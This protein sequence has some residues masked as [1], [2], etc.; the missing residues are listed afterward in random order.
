[1]RASPGMR[2]V[3][4]TTGLVL[5]FTQEASLQR[6][7][8]R[9][10]ITEAS[11]RGHM[12]FLAGDAMKGRGSGTEDEWRAAEYIGSCLLYTSPSPRDS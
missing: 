3:I 7:R 4:A 10:T 6:V 9:D 12:E 5:L 1:M 2:V 8:A 11:I